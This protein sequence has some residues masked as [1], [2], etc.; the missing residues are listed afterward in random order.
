MTTDYQKGPITRLFLIDFGANEFSEFKTIDQG[1]V[2][3]IA[4]SGDELIY[5]KRYTGKTQ[6]VSVDLQS[7]KNWKELIL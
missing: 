4:L 6:E 7:I 5:Q 2:E 1:F 3:N